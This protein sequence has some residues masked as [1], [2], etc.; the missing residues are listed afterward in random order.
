MTISPLA[1]EVAH[2]SSWDEDWSPEQLV[3]SSPGN[4]SS[5]TPHMS[6]EEELRTVKFKGWQTPKCPTYPQ[7]LIIHLL[8][9]PARIAKIQ[10]LSHH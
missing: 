1:Y 9:G 2:C 6:P 5:D 10:L 4:Q 8:C 3:H 7:D